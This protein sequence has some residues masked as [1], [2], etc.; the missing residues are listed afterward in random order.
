MTLAAGMGVGCDGV[1]G[2][3]GSTDGGSGVA[4]SGA[5]KIIEIVPGERGRPS[6]EV[7]VEVGGRGLAAETRVQVEIVES[8]A[9]TLGEESAISS[10]VRVVFPAESLRLE[11]ADEPVLVI[12]VEAEGGHDDG[13]LRQ[14]LSH[15][16]NSFFRVLMRS[17][18]KTVVA[19]G[20]AVV[21]GTQVVVGIG[22]D[23]LAQV[24]EGVESAAEVVVETTLVVLDCLDGVEPELY[25]VDPGGDLRPAA[26]AA[27]DGDKLPVVLVHGWQIDEFRCWNDA[28]RSKW[29]PFLRGPLAERF[30]LY[31]FRYRS[32]AAI[33]GNAVALAER[34][35]RD[36]TALVGHS[37]GGLVASRAAQIVEDVEQ[38]ITLGT[39]FHGSPWVQWMRGLSGPGM[40]VGCAVGEPMGCAVSGA[41]FLAMST[42]GALNLAWDA[43]DGRLLEADDAI[44]TGR[45]FLARFHDATSPPAVRRTVLVGELAPTFDEDVVQGLGARALQRGGFAPSDGIVPAGS[46]ADEIRS[47]QE[48]PGVARLDAPAGIT[49]TAMPLDDRVHAMV[50]ELLGEGEGEGPGDGPNPGPCDDCATDM[51]RI[52]AGEFLMGSPAD[53]PD[54]HDDE[55]QHRVEITRPFLLRATEVTQAEW[56]AVMGDNRSRFDE[57]GDDCPVEQVSWLEV[58]A[59][60]NA[61]SRAEGLEECYVIEGED[62]TWPRGLDCAGYRLPTEAEWEYAARAGTQTAWS[63]GAD[64]DCLDGVAWYSPNSGSRPHPVGTKAA[65]AWGLHDMHG[66]VW[67][68]VWDWYADYGGDAQVDPTGPAAGA[69]RVRRGGGWSSDATRLR[70][71]F[72]NRRPPTSRYDFL[73][74]RPARSVP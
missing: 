70:A 1:G 10:T 57:C 9:T 74:F 22:R 35:G 28:H 52:P 61:L 63:C 4:G 32:T 67:E 43:Y 25:R 3:D 64:V 2:G 8:P 41:T 44:V 49:H 34:L 12:A 26:A 62:V 42:P 18:G 23:A 29:T 30:A 27:A 60:C 16:E 14:P 21:D 59:F 11:D 66:N 39:P 71:A 40:N 51:V 13:V 7:E 69:S 24:V 31:T 56:E 5:R 36:P 50:V 58:V 47:G 6:N 45:E 73:G 48:R 33:E 38:V 19:V 15:H 20:A 55:T 72:R 65:N 46:A 17:G 68:W 37:M 53:E 54:R